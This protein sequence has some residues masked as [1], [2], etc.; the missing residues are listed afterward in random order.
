[1]AV[2]LQ[3]NPR[4]PSPCGV[5]RRAPCLPACLLG[6]LGCSARY[7]CTAVEVEWLCSQLLQL[8]PPVVGLDLEWRPQFTAGHPGNPTAL[9]QLCYPTMPDLAHDSDLSGGRGCCSALLHV[10][11]TGL[12]PSLKKLL[13][14]EVPGKVGVNISGDAQKL[15]RDFDL[16]LGGLLELDVVAK[17]RLLVHPDAAAGESRRW[18]LAALTEATLRRN[19]PKPSAVRCG[20]WEKK[21]LDDVQKRY[22]ALDS[23]ASLAVW[24]ALARMPLKPRPPAQV[25]PNLGPAPQP[26]DDHLPAGA[27][28]GDAPAAMD[29][30][31]AAAVAQP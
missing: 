25:H 24:A 21:P 17:D 19:L 5:L 23:Y 31:G 18:S 9:V 15:R 22:A 3:A 11:H 6:C 8:A 28:L 13:T 27:T 26:Q 2:G 14:S 10:M 7:A 16:L 1:M 20:N 29:E 30:E 4:R 12:T